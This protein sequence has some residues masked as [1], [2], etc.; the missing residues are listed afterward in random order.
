[1]N[2]DQEGKDLDLKNSAAESATDHDVAD[3]EAQ[4]VTTASGKKPSARKLGDVTRRLRA[5]QTAEHLSH[6]ASLNWRHDNLRVCDKT[7]SAQDIAPIGQL[8]ETLLVSRTAQA[9][10]DTLKAQGVSV[11]YD[12]Q[13]PLSQYYG[14]AEGNNPRHIITLNPLHPTGDLLNLLARELRRAWQNAQGALV[15]PLTYEPD[16]AILVNRAQQADVLMMAIKMAW[17]LKLAGIN[18]AWDYLTES[19]MADVSR[20][21]EDKAR[22]DFRTL[23]NGEAA[24]AA[25]DRFFEGSRTKVHDKRIIHQMLLDETGYIKSREARPHVGMELFQRLGE[26]PQGRNYLAMQ[27]AGRLPTDPAYAS[28]ED[29]SNAN[30]LWFI[31]FERSFQEKELQMLNESVR[32]SAEIVDLAKWSAKRGGEPAC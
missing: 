2:N 28:V 21:F 22:Q 29:R 20:L 9:L 12:R 18:E 1:M 31:K 7:P 5:G 25:Y 17:E 14:R 6:R 3:I 4:T 30:F 15:N 10:Y 24:R 27:A 32:L 11:V 26:V 8:L 13:V 16:E 23:N 19:S